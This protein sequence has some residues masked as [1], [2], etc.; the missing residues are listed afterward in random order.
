MLSPDDLTLDAPSSDR[1]APV[2]PVRCVALVE[3]STPKLSCELQ[4]LLRNRLRTA[5]LLLGT[6]FGVFFIRNLFLVPCS[7][8]NEIIM[9]VLDGVLAVV[10]A[11]L[12]LALCRRC[13]VHPLK[14]RISEV[15][16]FGLPAMYF[17]AGGIIGLIELH[18]SA[19]AVNAHRPPAIDPTTGSVKP[20][21]DLALPSA[22]GSTDAS[23]T[24]ISQFTPGKSGAAKTVLQHGL[25][26]I[27]SPVVPW[28][29]LIFVYA[30]FIPNTWQRAAWVL[31]T[32]ALIP[33]VLVV[34]ATV[35]SDDLARMFTFTAISSIILVMALSALSGICGVYTIGRLRSEAFEA[36]QLGQYRLTRLI[37]SGGM[38]EVYL[39]EHQLMKR[40]CAIKV[41]RP[42]KATD[43]QALLRFE[44]EVRAT[45]KLSHWNTVE[46]FDYGRTDDGTFYYVMEYLPGLS[47]AELV[48]R[49][50]PLS[51]ERSVFL[52]EQTCD[53]LT[54]AHAMGLI[55][56]DIKPGNIFA[57]QRGGHSDVAKLLDFGLAKRVASTADTIQLTQ[58]G[59][60]TGSPLYMSPEQ[61]T[62]DAEPDARSDIYA[63]GVVA[64][65][66]LTGKPPFPGDNPI[67][68][69]VAHATQQPKPLSQVDPTI[70]AD[71]EEVVMRCLA[72]DPNDRYQ[73]AG[74]LATALSSL[75]CCGRW[76]RAHARQW[77]AGR[78][79]TPLVEQ[80]ELAG[81]LLV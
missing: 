81:S 4:L 72:K 53:A 54:E 3:G 70:P 42:N 56:R 75:E 5:A 1:S 52:L 8:L 51:P 71:L 69:M 6:G 60:V 10:L 28:T 37:G 43:P 9:L 2:V 39:A 19:Q 76:T 38:G 78:S 45:A 74:A 64:Y 7:S 62:G 13:A 44:R 11:A 33:I 29:I 48:D 66:M 67:K 25:V 63:L 12:G 36:R 15:L 14:L 27:E 34:V 24:I 21:D 22:A 40:P 17:L 77:W 61:A 32:L 57:A 58:E 30:M 35:L 73:D 55:H 31:A 68:V 47:I 59:S 23:P 18:S 26:L 41:I 20:A 65:F 49:H 80:P 16:V 50:G 79:T 46:I